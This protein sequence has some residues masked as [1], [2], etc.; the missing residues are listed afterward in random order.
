MPK[1][2]KKNKI[3]QCTK[4]V[5]YRDLKVKESACKETVLPCYWYGEVKHK[6]LP[7]DFT[8]SIWSFLKRRV[9]PQNGNFSSFHS[10]KLINSVDDPHAF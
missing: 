6:I 9:S 7:A 3:E 1:I 10:D 2:K 8:K 4:I 5:I